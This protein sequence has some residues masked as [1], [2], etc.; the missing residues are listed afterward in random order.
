MAGR[1]RLPA[2]PFADPLVAAGVEATARLVAAAMSAADG[3]RSSGSLAMA[4]SRLVCSGV[5]AKYPNLRFITHHCGS[6]IIPGLAERINT[7]LEQYRLV[8]A[9]KW[10][11][12]G[13]EDPFTYKRPAEY[14][15]MFYADTALYGGVAELECGHAFFGAEHIVFGTD[16][17]YFGE[18][19]IKKTIDAV[20]K[21]NISDADKKLIFKDNARRILHLDI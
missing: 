19:Y 7:E 18:Q 10:D 5:L 2:V 21:M 11:Q 6:G 17:P 8:G 3:K 9:I 1:D 4:M 13:E 12:P 14:F 20:Y 15:K 16:F